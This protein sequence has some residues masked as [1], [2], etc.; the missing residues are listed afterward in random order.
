MELANLAKCLLLGL[1][2]LWIQ[3]HGNKGCFETERLALL[4]FKEFVGSNGLDVDYL[5]SSWVDN[6]MSDCCKWERVMCNSTTGHVTELSLNNTRQYDIE[7][8]SFY[9]D[10]NI[11]FAKLSMFQQL[12]E[13]RS[14][15]LSYNRI[16]GFI[17]DTGTYAMIFYLYYHFFNKYIILVIE[18]L[19][20][21]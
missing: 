14:L 20:F 7:S 2:I 4:G 1:I 16:G 13:L 18:T 15:N 5:L 9:D 8:I 6:S 21:F 10:E 3:I 17:D 19:N 12:K 11:W